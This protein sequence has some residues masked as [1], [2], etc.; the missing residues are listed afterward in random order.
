MKF[1][2]FGKALLMGALSVGAVLGVTSCVQ[3]YTVGFLFVT[4]TATAGSGQ[5]IISGFK[6]DHNSGNLVAINGMP[7]GS[8]GANPGRF[9]LA[10]GSRFLYVLNRG[11]DPATNGPCIATTVNCN[12]ANISQF[13]VGGTGILSFQAEYFSQGLNPFR[14]IV[15]GQQNYIYVL[16]AV[17]PSS[18]SCSLALGAGVTSC[19][20]ITAFKIDSAT[21]RLTLLVNAQVTASTGTPLAYF[22]VPAN[23]IDFDMT[24]TNVFTLSGTPASGDVV[25]PYGF[26]G[27]TGQLTIS[28][29]SVQPI[30]ATQATAIVAATTGTIYVLDNEPITIPAGNSA[31]FPPGVYLSQ[32]LPFTAASGGALEA[33]T[34]GAVPDDP[35]ESNPTFL[36]AEAKSK[37]VY[38]VNQGNNTSGTVEQSGIVGYRIDPQSHQLIPMA[39]SP[40]SMGSGPQCLLEDPSD[41]YIYTANFND[42][43]VSG[44]RVDTN[45][46]ALVGLK[47]PSAAQQF[48]L[49]GPAAWCV[50]SG[51]TN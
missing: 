17:A 12:G 40:F 50:K 16:D 27:A 28:Q 3:S 39:Q 25:F 42:S 7:V 33:Q 47:T 22:P 48:K 49:E 41:Q 46:G 5:G 1:R 6:I 36:I 13:A 18:S 31:N 45:S 2:K 34:G 37:F 15:D 32:I 30:G 21:G 43:T 51:R 26:S 19:G 9:V 23:P 35:N 44:R 20:D 10:D 14:I 11:T 24:G 38:V 8:K 29:N 4:G